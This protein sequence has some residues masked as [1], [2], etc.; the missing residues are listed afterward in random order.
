VYCSL[1]VRDKPPL[2]A[3]WCGWALQ[4]KQL[5]GPLRLNIVKRD[6]GLTI[7]SSIRV[8]RSNSYPPP[9]RQGNCHICVYM[10]LSVI[11]II[12][13]MPLLLHVE[14][15]IFHHTPFIM[16]IHIYIHSTY[17][18]ILLAFAGRQLICFTGTILL[19]TITTMDNDGSCNG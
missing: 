19:N 12:R 2:A 5:S 18:H 1:Y 6:P 10:V 7:R 4:P 17:M 9:S 11:Y 8:S 14:L 16:N 3:A 13:H 15:S